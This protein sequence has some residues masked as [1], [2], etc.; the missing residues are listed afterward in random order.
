MSQKASQKAT[1]ETIGISIW[2][3]VALAIAIAVLLPAIK[4]PAIKLPGGGK[5]SLLTIIGFTV[6]AVDFVAFVLLYALPWFV[7]VS[8]LP[9]SWGWEMRTYGYSPL[10][11][12]SCNMTADK[13]NTDNTSYTMASEQCLDSSSCWAVDYKCWDNLSKTSLATPET[14][15]FYSVP[16]AACLD[17]L[18]NK[19]GVGPASYKDGKAKTSDQLSKETN[20]SMVKEFKGW[21]IAV[22]IGLLVIGIALVIKGRNN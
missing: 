2:A 15:L 14:S 3:L 5:G 12:D 13:T 20:Y 21:L 10:L 18:K 17:L 11:H 6:L 1:A 16:K 19:K 9:T 7:G 22:M 4:S 8:L